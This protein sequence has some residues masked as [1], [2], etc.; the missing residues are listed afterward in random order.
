MDS[1][2]RDDRHTAK[3]FVHSLD[4][5]DI[6][7]PQL[8]ES[9][10]NESSTTTFD[11]TPYH[12]GD[13]CCVNTE[14]HVDVEGNEEIQSI[15]EASSL[16]LD[17]EDMVLSENNEL[18]EKCRTGTTAKDSESDGNDNL[19]PFK[20]KKSVSFSEC[21][22]KEID[23]DFSHLS[24]N[25]ENGVPELTK[26]EVLSVY[27]N[28][29]NK[30]HVDIDDKVVSQLSVMQNNSNFS[31]ILNLLDV[32]IATETLDIYERLF[33]VINFHKLYI[34]VDLLQNDA[35]FEIFHMIEYYNSTKELILFGNYAPKPRIWSSIAVAAS[36]SYN[37]LAN[38]SIH[39][40]RISDDG[41]VSIFN[42]INENPRVENLRFN[43]CKLI[44]S[45]NFSIATPLKNSRFLKELHLCNMKL[46]YVETT[47]LAP[48]LRN[49]HSLKVLNLSNNNI[50]D[51]GFQVLVKA[52]MNQE[53]DNGIST[54]MVA[55]NR[56]TKAISFS[57][58]ALLKNCPLMHSIN[59]GCNCLTDEFILEIK[60][61]LAVCTTLQVLGLQS[62][63]LTN[64]G[65]IHLMEI[66]TKNKLLQYLNLR[67]NR[68]LQHEALQT[69]VAHLP[70]TNLRHIELDEANRFCIDAQEY[71]QILNNI[72]KLLII[73]SVDQ[74]NLVDKYNFT[75][76]MSLS[77]DMDTI[78]VSL[79][80]RTPSSRG[81]FEIVSVPEINYIPIVAPPAA[82]EVASIL[83]TNS[84]ESNVTKETVKGPTL[85]A[86]NSQQANLL[87]IKSSD[88]IMDT[89][90][91]DD[92]EN[93]V[94]LNDEN[95]ISMGDGTNIMTS[96]KNRLIGFFKAK[97]KILHL[98]TDD[99]SSDDSTSN[100]NV[101]EFLHKSIKRHVI[102]IPETSNVSES[103]DNKIKDTSLEN[104]NDKSNLST[105][106]DI[107]KARLLEKEMISNIQL[108][109]TT[110]KY[111]PDIESRTFVSISEDRDFCKVVDNLVCV[112]CI[113]IKEK[114]MC[115]N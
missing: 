33:Q 28:I 69:I 74:P 27:Y 60:D 75:P 43:G 48:F 102:G 89:K 96:T 51:R 39:E 104:F 50:G 2:V 54:L 78:P 105:S 68:A 95:K 17:E 92:R 66:C 94:Q 88:K 81:R 103:L 98:T 5:D 97:S 6:L 107:V 70:H 26:E 22:T 40:L 42:S 67:D 115:E 32:I 30:L 7:C 100:P 56:L 29:C 47:M 11:I 36:N 99:D 25:C 23:V 8:K 31:M 63:L 77:C 87:K 46:Y 34:N 10:E 101:E 37:D 58:Q 109:E 13:D 73:K 49:N 85:Y 15:E 4:E 80:W 84:I 110:I 79:S 16:S 76:E 41:L 53:H 72:R 3:F 55:N 62:T 106:S 52:L 65:I 14:I 38:I 111:L 1:T 108:D 91:G 21:L 64:E 12:L 61:S 112:D 18:T 35:V 45:P 83:I 24:F 57:M 71:L 19:K 82:R 114:N 86:S 113:N 44:F 90:K 20:T 9:M 93:K 59:V